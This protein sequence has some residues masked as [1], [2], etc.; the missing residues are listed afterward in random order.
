MPITRY[1]WLFDAS[2]AGDACLTA[3]M[4]KRLPQN[5]PYLVDGVTWSLLLDV[6]GDFRGGCT[7]PP[8]FAELYLERSFCLPYVASLAVVCVARYPVNMAYDSVFS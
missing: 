5:E 2:G 3:Y 8:V 1:P 7:R 6:F 4:W